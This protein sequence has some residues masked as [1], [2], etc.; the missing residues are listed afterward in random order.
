MKRLR[1][2]K[3]VLQLMILVHASMA[4]NYNQS[5]SC[6]KRIPY[7]DVN[8]KPK[9]KI[10]VLAIEGEETAFST[11]NATFADYLSS[12]A[13]KRFDPPIAFEMVAVDFD[14]F[15]YDKSNDPL[16][17]K[18][19]FLFV[20]P[21]K[22]SC[23]ESQF[24]TQSLASIVF[25][26]T[27]DGKDVDLSEFAGLIITKAD[28]DDIDTLT[29]LKNKK[30][31][32]ISIADFGS[33]LMQFY[34][35]K[36]KG[37]SYINDPAQLVFTGAQDGVI[38]GVLNGT[39]DAGFIRTGIIERTVDGEGKLVDPS[40]IKIIDSRQD[41]TSSGIV[42]PYEHSTPLYPEWNFVATKMTPPEISREVQAAL[43]S[44]ARQG[45]TGMI[46]DSCL[47]TP[48]NN[49]TQC[50]DLTVQDP[51]ASCDISLETALAASRALSNGKYAGWRTTLSYDRVQKV[52]YDTGN[53]KNDPMSRELI[54]DPTNDLYEKVNCPTGYFKLSKEVFRDACENVGLGCPEGS[55][56]ICR[57]CFQALP[58]KV[59]PLSVYEPGKG[60]KEFDICGTMTQNEVLNF[61]IT[62][63]LEL[64]DGLNLQ[65]I[66]F[67]GEDEREIAVVPGPNPNQYTISLRSS[68]VG[69]MLLKIYDGEEQID[70]SPLR[71]QVIHRA[72]PRMQV[73]GEDG[74]CRC[75]ESAISIFGSCVGTQIIWIGEY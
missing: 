58:L 19:D 38:L 62:D 72:C 70:A 59:A 28:N 53:L 56:C 5:Q 26:T 47:R 7:D 24:G 49:S 54:C 64:T 12:T 73:A 10:G 32:A 40:K 2:K 65:V 8:S 34:E 15:V 17:K 71:V 75:V 42:F 68:Q 30:V 45:K 61:T 4:Q 23:I 60:C 37:M 3:L 55:E 16:D 46:I 67:E 39:F 20:N 35:M 1:T 51:E 66:A 50:N 52:L 21:Q 74:A 9:Y 14:E 11:Y 57:P 43:L 6:F 48:I 36:K 69:L 27:A 41:M 25:S 13:G 31:A 29:D 18:F 44:I 22:T 63:N 33:G